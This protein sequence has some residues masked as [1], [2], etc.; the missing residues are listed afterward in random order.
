MRTIALIPKLGNA[1]A[2][3]LGRVLFAE[4]QRRG[5]AVIVEEGSGLSG[6]PAVPG[7]VLAQQADLFVVLGGDGTL[8]H[9]A[10]LCAGREVPIL[11]VN[12]GTL[13][14][15]TEVPREQALEMVERALAGDLPISRRSMLAIEAWRGEEPLQSSFALNDAAICKGALARL[16]RLTASV[17]GLLAAEYEADGLIV[18]TPT[19]ST[20]YSLSAGGPIVYPTLEAVLLTPI[21]PHS[22]TQRPLVLPASMPI[23]ITLVGEAEMFLSIDGRR[24]CELRRGDVVRASLASQHTLLLGNPDVDAFSILRAK[25]RWGR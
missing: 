23:E 1:Q 17:G 9:A 13:G 24:G 5:H 7:E 21:C 11:G 15:L 6:L 18:A 2:V 20:A 3:A 10:G 12:L 25:L 22:L 14:Y 4:L 19:G 16:T 8:L